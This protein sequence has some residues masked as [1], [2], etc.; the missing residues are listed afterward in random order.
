MTYLKKILVNT[1]EAETDSELNKAAERWGARVFSKPDLKEVIDIDKGRKLL[2]REECNY[3]FMANFDFIVARSDSTPIFAV[4]YDGSWHY[5]DPVTI[6]RDRKKNAICEKF[7]FPLFRID[8]NYLKRIGKFSVIGWLTELW[9][10]Y[11]MWCE[12]QQEGRIPQDEPFMFFSIVGYDPFIAS[13]AFIQKLY[14]KSCILTPVPGIEMAVDKRGYATAMAWVKVADNVIIPGHAK[15]LFFRVPSIDPSE[16]A[17]ELAV[18][19][20]RENLEKYFRGKYRPLTE[21]DFR[22]WQNRFA[23]GNL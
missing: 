2:T 4:E 23:L 13:R 18:V 5:S 10:I 20:A 17:E 1:Y 19:D 21:K 12:A 15:C 14:E 9:F 6:E 11:E 16:L 22:V 8:S 7:G 3:A